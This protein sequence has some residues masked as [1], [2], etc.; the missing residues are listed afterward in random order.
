MA[1]SSDAAMVLSFDVDGD[2]AEHDDW[3]T[4]EH[5]HERLS[6]PGFVRATRWIA[7]AG[8]P[9]Y[10][11]VYEV[12]GTEVATSP[13][14]LARL[15]APTPWTSA[16]MPRY[17]GMVRGFCDVAATAG[18]GLGRAAVALRFSVAGDGAR[19]RDALAGEA[20]P[21]V[22]ARRGVAAIHLFVPVRP[23][24]M[25]N[26]QALRGRDSQ[27][28]WLALATGHEPGALDDAVRD[29]LDRPALERLGA[30]D[31][32]AP[33]AYALHYTATAREVARAPAHVVPPSRIA[34]EAS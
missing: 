10:L 8:A 33:A 6:I 7:A 27:P 18:Y 12:E 15:N 14:Y 4:F 2:P 13:H 3:H 20:F 16:M 32:S 24:P 31:V 19:L 11:V 9:R 25:T 30:V 5:L 34:R 21:A 23:P 28:A 22:A 17:R 26:E 29:H 1:L